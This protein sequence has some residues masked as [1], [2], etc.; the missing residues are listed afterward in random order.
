[1]LLIF[2][3]AAAAGTGIYLSIHSDAQERDRDRT[4]SATLSGTISGR[5][6]LDYNGDALYETTGGTADAPTAVDVGVAG[7]TVT[8]YDAAGVARGSATSGADGTYSIASAGTGPYRIEFT[9]IPSGYT[10]S[11]RSRASGSGNAALPTSASNAGA[12]VQFVP[13]GANPNVNLALVKATDYCQ[14][15][16]DIASQLYS[17]GD[18]NS[19][20][21]LMSVTYRA[22]STRTGT[23]NGSFPDAFTDFT[24]PGYSGLAAT[25]EIGTTFGLAYDRVN[26]MIYASAYMKRHSMFGP[27]GTGAIYKVD[28]ASSTASLYVDLNAVFGAGTAGAN[29]H[30][31]NNWD[32]DNNNTAWDAVGKTALGG[33]AISDD[34]ANLF[35]MNLANRRLYKIPTSGTLDNTT[36]TS[37]AFPT[38]NDADACGQQRNYRPFAVSYYEGKVY[39][40]AVCST[41][42]VRGRWGYVFEVD[43]T[44]LTY[45]QNP[46]LS[47]S[48]RYA[49]GLA[50]P[51]NPG[52]WHNWATTFQAVNQNGAWTHPQPMFT[53][54]DFDR[55]N[56]I[57][58]IRDRMGDQTGYQTL[59]NPNNNA[60]SKGITAG[61]ILRACGDPTNG[62]TLE[63][64]GRCGGGG[65]APQNTDE[66]P[67]GAEFYFQ[68]NYHTDS[69]PHAEVGLGSAAQIPGHNEFI[70]GIFDPIYLDGTNVY[71]SQ[72]FRWFVNTGATA[73]EQ[74]RGYQANS[75]DFGKANGIGNIAP[76]CDAA[77]IELGNRVWRDTNDNGVQ[78]PGEPGIAGVTVHLYDSVGTL[79]GTAVT[80]ANGEYYFVSSTVAD[81]NTGDNIGQV[82]GGIKFNSNYSIRL[83]RAADYQTGGP[84]FG[85]RKARLDV[86]SQ[87]GFADGSDSDG[88]YDAATGNFLEINLTTGA[89]GDN[90]HNYD[91]GFVTAPS[92]APV[93]VSGLVTTADGRGIINVRVSLTEESGAIRTALTGPFGYFRFDDVESGQGVVLA[94]S[95]KRFT[96]AQP[97]RFI[98]LDDNIADADWVANP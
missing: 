8:L 95:A 68:E 43:P 5:V 67:G 83:D 20:D 96:F 80:D 36:I 15:N 39:V 72:G 73:G 11:A 71:D 2:A 87:P 50:D 26:K 89:P 69:V 22:G 19:P 7:V 10:P 3:V 18:T 12:T 84:L 28:P 92:A 93:S 14:D 86:A 6:F 44:S 23:E 63:S 42:S 76:L 48:L 65:S 51:G 31:A 59:S 94:V 81:P 33:M 16:P 29:A 9:T 79:V 34:M 64:N 97:R 98:S 61:E 82:N 57:I 35:V 70:A 60:R 24:A 78:D 4:E 55:G 37:V 21:A 58:S 56:M 85:L 38:P 47:F 32:R 75:G 91:F 52:D 53:D 17:Y 46:I 41:G 88:D 66:G 13:D 40:G 49:R 1:M 90:D 45:T 74:N 54:L 30:D 25:T 27:N 77:P 62:W